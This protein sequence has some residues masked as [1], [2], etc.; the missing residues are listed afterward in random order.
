M[1]AEQDQLC[2]GNSLTIC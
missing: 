1:C 2:T